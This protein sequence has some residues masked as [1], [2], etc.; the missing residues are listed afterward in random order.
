VGA[1]DRFVDGLKAHNALE[2]AAAIA[3]WFF[4]SLLPLLAMLGWLVSQVARARGVDALLA[5]VLDVAPGTAEDILR[6][7]IERMAGSTTSVAPL[8]VAGFLWTASSGL[9]N[10]M[11]VFET[12]AKSEPRRWWKK[13]TIALGWVV[14][15][16]GA[17]CLLAWLLVNVDSALHANDP[18]VPASASASAPA[19]A[20]A[21]AP[22]VDP[23]SSATP[24]PYS[25]DRLVNHPV[26]TAA[27]ARMSLKRRFTSALHTPTEELIATGL[28][29]GVGMGFLAAFY[30]FAVVHPKDVR[31]RFWPGTFTAVASWLVVS[32]GF[33]LYAVSMSS[34]ALYYGSLAAVAV[35]MVWLYLTSLS[36]VVGAEVNAYLER[37][38]SQG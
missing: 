2:A 13:R 8:G 37:R 6:R 1:A 29:L 19:P 22:D 15:G 34:Y 11:D 30:R 27:H 24:P 31:R 26:A 18:P 38:T 36:L 35:M 5:P 9:H 23:P 7:E 28:L 16:L 17:A 33:G 20:S 25:L 3:F 21:S 32:W 10:L 12:A 14:V 4:L